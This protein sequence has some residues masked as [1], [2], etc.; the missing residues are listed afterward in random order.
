MRRSYMQ[1]EGI[2]LA[3]GQSKGNDFKQLSSGP[4]GVFI[5]H[6]GTVY[7]ADCDNHRVMRWCTGAREGSIVVGG[8][9]V[10]K[11]SNQLSDP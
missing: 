3:G 4:T 10:R 1:K 11:G 9:G 6:L 7:V 5:D 2:V 8:N